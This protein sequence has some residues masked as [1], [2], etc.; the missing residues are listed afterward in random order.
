MTLERSVTTDSANRLQCRQ[1]CLG[2]RTVFA[3]KL[4]EA[5]DQRA[6]HE[7][8]APGA[9]L[10][11]PPDAGS[12]FRDGWFLPAPGVPR[13]GKHLRRFHVSPCETFWY[14]GPLSSRTS[15]N[16]LFIIK[17]TR[18]D[19][20][21]PAAPKRVYRNPVIFARELVV[22]LER[23]HLTRQQL[24]DRH[25]IS[26]DRVIQWLALLKLPA[27]QLE[28]IAALGDYW[29]RPVVTERGMRRKRRSE[30]L[31]QPKIGPASRQS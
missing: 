11:Q 18:P 7:L 8:P 17:V 15:S 1:M 31:L 30:G 28:E 12:A 3:V 29:D 24:A 5:L 2:A 21:T 26:L 13:D 9:C 19:L 10:R 14:T 4:C 25:G 20:P 22:E 23:D 6:R 27:E 16:R